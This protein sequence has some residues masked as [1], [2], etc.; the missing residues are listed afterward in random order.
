MFIF[1]LLHDFIAD[2]AGSECEAVH[3]LTG[4]FTV[5]HEFKDIEQTLLLSSLFIP[6]KHKFSQVER[7]VPWKL[8]LQCGHSFDRVFNISCLFILPHQGQFFM[9][10]GV[11]GD[12]ISSLKSDDIFHILWTEQ[13]VSLT[14]GLH[15]LLTKSDHDFVDDTH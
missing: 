14:I 13:G 5:F 1:H 7:H 15:L 8:A 6:G 4:D 9:H 3:D 2:G 12:K 11:H 10:V